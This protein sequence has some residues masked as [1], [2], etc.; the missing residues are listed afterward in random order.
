MPYVRLLSD[1]QFTFTL[2][3]QYFN[4]ENLRR[5]SHPYLAPSM[6][7]VRDYTQMTRDCKKLDAGGTM[8]DRHDLGSETMPKRPGHPVK[9]KPGPKPRY[10]KI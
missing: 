1:I 5:R 2:K 6:G 9:E 7:C 10:L 3:T 8:G 4:Y